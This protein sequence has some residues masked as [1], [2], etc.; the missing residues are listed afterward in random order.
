MDQECGWI[1]ILRSCGIKRHIVW[2]IGTSVS[3]NIFIS[4]FLS[5]EKFTSERTS[6]FLRLS[7]SY[8]L[9]R[10]LGSP[11]DTSTSL[12]P[13]TYP[14]CLCTCNRSLLR[15][16]QLKGP[17]QSRCL[18]PVSTLCD[19]FRRR[20]G[21]STRWMSQISVS[22]LSS[23]LRRWRSRLGRGDLAVSNTPNSKS[24]YERL[25]SK[26]VLWLGSLRAYLSHVLWKWVWFLAV[27]MRI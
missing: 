27:L 16:V 4:I 8:W 2:W 13:A 22:G 25:S 23:G 7:V 19:Q 26:V 12:S 3:K 6:S 1:L 11:S 14:K 15:R 21:D 17:L 20:H 18:C 9:D 10:S 5:E 24:R